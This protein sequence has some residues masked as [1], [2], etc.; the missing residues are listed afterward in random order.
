MTDW[1]YQHTVRLAVNALHHFLALRLCYTAAVLD[2][3]DQLLDSPDETSLPAG[4]G[5]LRPLVQGML[6]APNARES[7]LNLRRLVEA[8]PDAAWPRSGVALRATVAVLSSGPELG[9]ILA[10]DPGRLDYLTDPT[11]GRQWTRD[12][13][14]QELSHRLA[15][16]DCPKELALGL[17][18]FRNDHYVR[19][20]ACEFTDA[21]LEQVGRELA[22]LADLCVS[23]ALTFALA[24][25]ARAH[26]APLNSEGRQVGMT[27]IAMGKYGAQELN[28]CS[29][30]DV[31]YLYDTD[32]GAAGELSLHE[33]FSNACQQVTRLLSETNAE[34]LCFRVDLG[35]RPEGS[36]GPICN[37]LA[38]AERYYETWGGP[39]DR[40]AWLKARAAA[41]D[42]TLGREMVDLLH[43]F[44]FPRSIRP[45][46]VDQI[47]ELNR[48]IKAQPRGAGWNVK[49]HSG[50]IREVEF[51][52]QSLQ[53]LHAGKQPALQE[54]ATLGALDRLLF[55]GLI[56]EQEHRQLAEAYELWRRIEHRLQLHGGRQ[57]H[58]LPDRHKPLYG[59][60]AGHMGMTDEELASQ[61]RGHRQAVE[62]IYE[63]LGVAPQP[64]HAL[65]P[66]L[67]PELPTEQARKIL[68]EAG[69]CQT[70]RAADHLALLAAKPWGPLGRSPA[71]SVG[72]LALPL[73]T[74]VAR[75]PDPDAALQHLMELSL[76]FGPYRGLWE[77]LAH[78]RETLRLLLSLFGTSDYLARIFKD[79]PELLDRLL[80]AGNAQKLQSAEQLQQHL[81][82]RFEPLDA[83]DTEAHLLALARFRNEQV[84]R[85]GLHDIAGTLEQQQ[86]WAQLSD[87]A[88]VVLQQLFEMVLADTRRRYGTPHHEDGSEATLAV[89]SLGKLG[90]RELTYASD[91][92][93]IFVYSGPGQTDGGRQVDNAEFY[94]RAAQRLINALST[95]MGEGQL[96]EVDTRL[97][98]SGNQGTLVCS[99]RAFRDYHRGSGI[100]E[101]QVLIKARAVAGDQDHGRALARWAG[102]F[103]FDTPLDLQQ[104]RAEIHQHRMR[105]E[106]ELAQESDG[107]HDL[108]LGRG[109]LLDI[110][111]VVQYLQLC[112][113][114]DP[115]VRVSST[116]EA[117]EALQRGGHLGQ[118]TARTLKQGYRF[119]RRLEARLRMVRDRPAERL[120]AT[121]AGLE[122][123]ARRLG[124]RQQPG[125]ATPGAQLLEE[126]HRQTETVRRIYEE[127]LG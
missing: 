30:I 38:G 12:E 3:L 41:G 68:G 105:M 75:S 86:V 5:S 37:S 46:I 19:L 31:I 87:L 79:H 14:E 69:F 72:A 125:W 15:G 60:V 73:L 76:R 52:V 44:V 29:D 70:R 80:M 104:A 32:E 13:L 57:T 84:L 39:W 48:R 111:F 1:S 18:R 34:G 21:P 64:E 65:S 89:L 97:R 126:Y 59:Q 54:R 9:R 107:F 45:E 92:D 10:R 33:F 11:L 102:T 2:A 43:P 82:A 120:P 58:L 63:T 27:V 114:A 110:D 50:G 127:H 113:G 6:Q 115:A 16:A 121:A 66:L 100:W 108:K 106:R 51:F 98:P 112:H 36:R 25:L 122:V 94:T 88:E 93:L 109:G 7:L 17:T 90:S 85:I 96:Y 49:L 103:V 83:G 20:A 71:P 95:N 61:V 8:A 77:L 23:S 56:S 101:R 42:L 35:L 116:L 53:L 22:T 123:M 124:Y 99:D 91:L 74:E 81:R 118:Q 55:A 47:Q 24:E 67:D 119:L 40:L 4:L 26:G 62:Q 78:N 28:F 117:L